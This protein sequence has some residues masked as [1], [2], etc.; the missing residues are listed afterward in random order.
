MSDD[1]RTGPDRQE[2]DWR[3]PLL[4][5]LIW[6]VLVV[7]G[8]VTV[9]AVWSLPS[10]DWLLQ[11]FLWLLMFATA[12]APVR[13]Y[14]ARA[15]VL[16]LVLLSLGGF[17]IYGY[18]ILGSGRLFLGI[19]SVLAAVLL[20]ARAGYTFFAVS[21]GLMILIGWAVVTG[22]HGL[23]DPAAL[24]SS[25][26]DDW[27][28]S[29]GAYLV[30]VGLGLTTGI[31]ILERLE[32]QLGQLKQEI[33]KKDVA[34]EAASAT[35]ENLRF[36][37]DSAAD[38]IWTMDLEGNFTYISPSVRQMQ[39]YSAE[40]AMEMGMGRL[41]EPDS[42]ESILDTIATELAEDSD[43]DPDRSVRVETRLQHKDGQV[44]DVEIMN[45]FLR[46]DAGQP[47]GIIGITRDITER[48]RFE[49]AMDSVI[50]GTRRYKGQDFFDSLTRNLAEV[51]GI[52]SVMVGRVLE[53]GAIRTLSFWLDDGFVENFE[54]P[55]EETPCAATLEE[56]MHSY[57][58]SLQEHFP[59]HSRLADMGLN[60]YLGT[61]IRDA[62][63]K[64]IGIL[65]C[66]DDKS[67]PVTKFNEDLLLIFAT[68]A[69]AE[70]SRRL[71]E[72]D[73]EEVKRQLIQAQKLESIGQLAGGVAHDFNNLLVVIQGY[74]D[75]AEEL[76][77]DNRELSEYHGHIRSSAE[78]AADL[79][80]QLLSFSR[81][82][83]MDTKPINLN[84]LI[85]NIGHLLQ[86]L[87]PE[88]I[89]FDFIP[90]SS[91]GTIEG[92]QSQLEQAVVNLAVNARDAMPE[93]GKLTIETEN[94][95]I[96]Q[97]YVESHPW[98]GVGRYVLLRVS[99]T[100]IGI[101]EE[102]QDRVF[103]P[104][105]TT[106]PEGL[107]T[108]LGLSV[109]FGV[110]KQHG[111]F[112][113]LYSEPGKGTEFR[114]YLPIVERS[115]SSLERKLVRGVTRGTETILLVEDDELVRDL[116]TTFL[117]RAGYK[118]IPAEDGEIALE[119]FRQ[120]SDSIS[121]VILDVVLPKAG[122]REVME[123]IH[124]IRP[125][126]RILF[127]SGYSV[128]GIHTNFILEDNLVLLQKPYS[129]DDLLLKIREMI[130]QGNRQPPEL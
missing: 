116:A 67:M 84:E 114:I 102:A 75:L 118:I 10:R 57:T 25:S 60:S 13:F 53:H 31:F 81:R 1:E 94:I 64:P 5:R 55:L 86:R 119:K 83:I 8:M 19:S 125:D 44:I 129:R 18:G 82:Q 24:V 16:C 30:I 29:I 105:Y 20:G 35:A 79:T 3:E 9:Y 91:L 56:E 4:A 106:K 12:F 54:A 76:V 66:M 45:R 127:T 50:R 40:E 32:T 23:N 90:G 52:R 88:S 7:G 58:D 97:S 39:G 42:L 22:V 62:N 126:T 92:D 65:A 128:N 26:P 77:T 73:S 103:E 96:D 33:Y 36:L 124:K 71:A 110:V 21:V 48:K 121:L 117:G 17:M 63:G 34:R 113:H 87:L 69:G 130:D 37:T 122:G 85:L 100:G 104:F 120:Y 51:L 93:G 43:R 27:F 98:A 61:P 111:G 72:E 70:L 112:T 95:V 109:L 2:P 108:G 59:G 74:V 78:R 28:F 80:R 99:D 38:V 49:T 6:I 107:G 47:I 41:A 11:A 14:Q 68:H 15:W 115:A 46:N 89:Q 123:E 101:P